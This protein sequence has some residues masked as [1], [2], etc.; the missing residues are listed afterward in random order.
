MSPYDL[1]ALRFAVSGLVL[2]PIIWARGSGGMSPD[3]V[4]IAAAIAALALSVLQLSLTDD[5][6]LSAEFAAAISD[7]TG[8]GAIGDTAPFEPARLPSAP[9]AAD[10]A[11]PYGP[12]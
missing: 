2:L 4:V 12:V 10:D 11:V 7:D 1:T 6:E 5:A 3:V 8:L 9:F